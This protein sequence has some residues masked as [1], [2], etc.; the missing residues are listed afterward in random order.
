[1]KINKVLLM[2]PPA[3]TFKNA[4]DINPMPPLGLGYLASVLTEMDIEVKIT[5]CLLEGWAREEGVDDS[6]IRTGLSDKQIEDLISDFNPDMIGVNCQFSRQFRIYHRM[7]SI[8]KKAKPSCVVVAGGAHVSACPEEVLA[9]ANCDYVLQ[10]EAEGT[11]KDLILALRQNGDVSG[12]DGAGWKSGAV[13]HVNK[14]TRWVTDLDSLPF[15]SYDIMNVEKYFGFKA[16]HGLRHKERFMPIMTSRGCPAK[17]TFC[18]ARKVWGGNYR[19]RSV[20]NV[21]AEMRML[22]R[23]YGVEELMFEDDNVTAN[24]VRAK[25]LFRQMINEELGFVWDTPNGIGV[26]SLDEEALDLMKG[27]GCVRL[28][29]PIESGSQRVVDN[30][31]KKPVKLPRVKKLINYCRKIDLDCGI[32]LVIG[33]PGETVRDIWSSFRFA[34]SCGCYEPHISVAT[35][36]PGTKLFEE[37]GQKGFFAREFTLDD[38]FIRSFMIRTPQWSEKTLE[39][40]LSRGLLYLKVR[41]FFFDPK[42]SFGRLARAVK[43]PGLILAFIKQVMNSFKPAGPAAERFGKCL[44]K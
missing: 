15:P 29:F 20:E 35:P 13:T 16:S 11:I 3:F 18:S 31:I 12:I 6:V 2:V 40:L 30:I 37:C 33:M 10:G 28:N 44:L 38:L 1:M 34:A 23:Q 41:S 19:F 26:W 21:L 32:F 17:C 39:K 24:S 25:E 42:R 27:S 8:V 43:H 7:F 4:R 9:D 5:D 36:Y 22:K 14:K